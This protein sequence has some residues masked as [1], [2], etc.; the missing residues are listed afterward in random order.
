MQAKFTALAA[1]SAIGGS[2]LALLSGGY[3][4]W[5][6]LKLAS[7]AGQYS[8]PLCR[9]ASYT[10]SFNFL[11]S[12]LEVEAGLAG[13][14]AIILFIGAL[15]TLARIPAGRW[16]VVAGCAIIIEHTIIGGSAI[17]KMHHWFVLFAAD[18]FGSP[19]FN[20]PNVPVMATL[21][22]VVPVITAALVMLPT[23]RSWWYCWWRISSLEM[24]GK[25]SSRLAPA[26]EHRIGMTTQVI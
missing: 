15:C 6:G 23:T 25:D 5:R 20:A 24:L 2:I 26:L 4:I 1:M 12:W 13:T 22:F 21:S 14:A 18:D 11:F 16:F 9:A 19:W 7:F 17:I 10:K 3:Q 8:E